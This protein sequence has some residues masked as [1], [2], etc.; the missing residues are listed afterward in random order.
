MTGSLV[1]ETFVVLS[2]VL[3]SV[4]VVG[5]KA[6]V[7]CT[8]VGPGSIHVTCMRSKFPVTCAVTRD[9]WIDE[10]DPAKFVASALSVVP[11]SPLAVH[12][13]CTARVRGAYW[14]SASAILRYVEAAAFDVRASALIRAST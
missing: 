13:T 3:I 4:L 14:S 9:L 11:S 5:I 10:N 6:C 7:V 1:A 12:V 2:L 8:L